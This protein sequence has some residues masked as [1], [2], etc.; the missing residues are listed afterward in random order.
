MCVTLM[1][2]C[3][4]VLL[5]LHTGVVADHI[6]N[7]LMPVFDITEKNVTNCINYRGL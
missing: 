2:N 1:L 5:P 3:G 4:D 7:G 6:A